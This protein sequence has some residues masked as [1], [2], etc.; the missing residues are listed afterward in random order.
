MWYIYGAGVVTTAA[1]LWIEAV[2]TKLTPAEFLIKVLMVTKVAAPIVTIWRQRRW[3]IVAVAA[4]FD[5]GGL[6]E[7]GDAGVGGRS[8]GGWLETVGAWREV[9][10]ICRCPNFRLTGLVQCA[11]NE[12]L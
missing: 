9:F 12:L 3:R 2:A 1:V 4:D 5:D 6:A 7:D 10:S 8:E 11:L